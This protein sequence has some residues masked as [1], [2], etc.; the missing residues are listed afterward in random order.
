MLA[1]EEEECEASL[2]AECEQVLTPP[3]SSPRWKK[4]FCFWHARAWGRRA[5]MENKSCRESYREML[6]AGLKERGE[7]KACSQR[8][9]FSAQLD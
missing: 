4:F 5:G 3:G 1:C 7:G 2:K 8:C 6:L 9:L